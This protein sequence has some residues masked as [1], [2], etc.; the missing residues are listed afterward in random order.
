M[1]QYDQCDIVS[2]EL[3]EVRER[4]RTLENELRAFRKKKR[5]ASW[6]QDTKHKRKGPLS[7][8]SSGKFKKKGPLSPQSSDGEVHVTKFVS[9]SSSNTPMPRSPTPQHTSD[10]TVVLSSATESESEE[11]P[12]IKDHPP[13]KRS[14]AIHPSIPEPT[15]STSALSPQGFSPE[16]KSLSPELQSPTLSSTPWSLPYRQSFQLGLPVNSQEAQ[17][18]Q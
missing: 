17:G 1:K 6:Y 4:K 10:S 12:V 5:Q 11:R 8:Q 9:R 13:L 15:P 7:P 14:C 2:K 3:Q 18:G 16:L